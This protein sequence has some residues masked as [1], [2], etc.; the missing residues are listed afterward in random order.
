MQAKRN[1]DIKAARNNIIGLI[2]IGV[3]ALLCSV[4]FDGNAATQQPQFKD[5]LAFVLH[6]DD[7]SIYHTQ[8]G[9]CYPNPGTEGMQCYVLGSDM[10]GY[11]GA[12]DINQVSNMQTYGD[13]SKGLV[14]VTQLPAKAQEDALT[15]FQAIWGK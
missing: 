1:S 5:Q 2:I 8:Y 15:S 3:F 7:Q 12:G 11:L 4:S 14:P 9:W 6:A 10:V 13:V